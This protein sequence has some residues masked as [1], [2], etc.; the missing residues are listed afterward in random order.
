M[1][2][3]LYLAL[4]NAASFL[5][6][7]L[8]KQRAIRGARRISERRL[9]GLAAAG[10]GLGAAAGQRLFQHKTRKVPFAG[11]LRLILAVQ[12]LLAAVWCWLRL[13]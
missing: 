11:R 7:G 10:G 5:A 8:D 12:A 13:A 3:G 2:A 6:F 4:I 9:L 1:L